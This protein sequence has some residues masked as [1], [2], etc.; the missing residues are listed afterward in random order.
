MCQD[1]PSQPDPQRR[2]GVIAGLALAIVAGSHLAAQGQTGARGLR[3]LCAAPPGG[4]PDLIARHYAARL[5][6]V[7][8][9]WAVVENRPGAAGLIAVGA[10]QQAAAD[11]RTTLLGHSGLVTTYPFLYT[12]L[13]YDA[14]TDLVPVAPAAE[15]AFAL[16]V[17]PAVPAEVRDLGD[18]A[19]WARTDAN[20][21]TYGTPGKGTLAHLMGALLAREA[22]FEA[23]HVPYG[24]GPPA[25]A[26]L[27]G[28]RLS[29]VVLPEGLLHAW[30]QAGSLR[31]LATSGAS[32]GKLLPE[33]P[34]LA[35]SGFKALVLREWWG[36]Y[37]PRGTQAA[38]V[39][40]LALAVRTAA[41]ASDLS[42]A[43]EVSGMRALQGTTSQMQE[44]IAR[45]R[46]FWRHAIPGTGIRMH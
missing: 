36:F 30:H 41:A 18:Y 11:G 25:I 40:T 38:V 14:S 7:P 37:L 6:N 24:G 31:V 26:E 33:V 44:R 12:R 2:A 23:Q 35:E 42:S 9:A 28:G 39:E 13:G 20:R 43:L 15:T 1:H 4:T 27:I 16:A 5:G 32:R 45:E 3:I 19:R 46:A 34:T 29:S 21:V 22:G 8:P 17:G 10:L